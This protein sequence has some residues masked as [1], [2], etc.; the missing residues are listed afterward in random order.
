VNI[1]FMGTP[2]FAVP[3][4]KKLFKNNHKIAAVVTAPDKARGRGKKVSVTPVKE[5]ALKNNIPILQPEKLK[6]EKFIEALENFPADLFVIVA[7]RILPEEVFS[8]P[9]F[10][11]FNLHASLLPKYRGAAPIQWAIIK[12]ETETGVTTFKLAGKVDTGNVY[13]QRKINITPEDD[14]G[15]LHDK[16]SLL[17]A[18]VVLQTVGLIESESYK[19][20]PQDD[21]LATPAPKI[22]KETGRINWQTPAVE[23]LNLVR[24]LSPSPAAFFIF[25]EKPFKIYKASVNKNVNLK[26]GEI[27]QNKGELIIGCG[28]DALSILEIQQEGRKRM[29]TASFLRGFNFNKN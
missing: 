15:S 8:L 19:L 16:L 12:G 23:I 1:I 25:D 3:S 18:D 17:G 22:S 29:D 7:F 14:F 6:D 27:K 21:S 24:G 9:R 26:P 28:E 10:G 5:F 13:F 2:D 20:L 11:S 4:L